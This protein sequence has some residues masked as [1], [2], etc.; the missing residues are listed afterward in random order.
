MSELSE[1]KKDI[2]WS[3]LLELR[4]ELVESQKIRT[5][6]IGFKITFVTAAIG[7]IAT[8]VITPDIIKGH[9]AAIYRSLFIIP[10]FA[11]IFFDFLI[12]SY[13]FSIKRIGS[14]CRYI[15]EPQIKS[16][17]EIGPDDDFPLWEEFIDVPAAKQ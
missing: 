5:Q 15:I 16:F 14:Y 4:K 13:S 17:C 6:I 9:D 2:L 1:A 8:K 11:A 7:V 10:A 3:L 12:Y